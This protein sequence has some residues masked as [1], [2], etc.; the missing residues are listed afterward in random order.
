MMIII[1]SP[2]AIVNEAAIINALFDEGMEVF[3]LRKP[4]ATLNELRQLLGNIKPI[5]YPRIALHQYHHLVNCFNINR[6]HFTEEKRKT[7]NEETLA[8]LKER[9]YLL[10]TSIHSLNAYES[11]SNC[12]NYTFFGPVFKSIS[13]QGYEA[14]V[15]NNFVFPVKKGGAKAIAL[16]GICIENMQQ[17]MIMKFNGIAALGAIW[18]QPDDSVKQ[19]KNLQK[20]WNQIGP[21]Y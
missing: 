4:D 11:L 19:F 10:S 3:H 12:F 5:Y 8:K 20:A 17:A 7:I 21:S 6:L 18:Q 14:S 9:N 2:S 15:D 13:K 16:G 1:S